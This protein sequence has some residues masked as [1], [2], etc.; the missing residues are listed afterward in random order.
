MKE[1]LSINKMFKLDYPQVPK[2]NCTPTLLNFKPLAVIR[3]YSGGYYWELCFDTNDF[4]YKI[5][6]EK[7]FANPIECNEHLDLFCAKNEITI[8]KKEYE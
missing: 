3:K 1:L 2:Q 5:E 7:D 6:C 8:N 4:T